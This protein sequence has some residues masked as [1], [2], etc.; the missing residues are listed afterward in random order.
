MGK[1]W[2]ILADKVFQDKQHINMD[3]KDFTVISNFSNY[4]CLIV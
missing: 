4:S 2:F 3:T 1:Y